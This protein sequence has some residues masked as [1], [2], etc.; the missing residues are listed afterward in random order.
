MRK[1]ILL[2]LLGLSASAHAT[3]VQYDL[4]W[5]LT[6]QPSLGYLVVLG[7]AATLVL[8]RRHGAVVLERRHIA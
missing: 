5:M 8:R 1:T 3:N 7:F 6:N 4:S 2:A